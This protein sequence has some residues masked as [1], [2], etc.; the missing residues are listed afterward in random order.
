MSALD[1]GINTI[2]PA[3][4][5]D[6]VLIADYADEAALAAYPCTRRPVS[7]TD[8]IRCLVAER[9]CVDFELP[10]GR[11]LR[12]KNAHASE[13]EACASVLLKRV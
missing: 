11:Q 10:A 12:Q 8:V 5:W 2:G 3:A 4:N 6:V 13:P 7:V 9:R 1:V